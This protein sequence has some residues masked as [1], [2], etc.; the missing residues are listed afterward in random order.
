MSG[1]WTNRSV[2]T[3]RYV[4]IAADCGHHIW[5]PVELSLGHTSCIQCIR[6]DI[7]AHDTEVKW[8]EWSLPGREG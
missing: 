2:W 5:E 1:Q 4:L 3:K 7:R 6:P 8:L